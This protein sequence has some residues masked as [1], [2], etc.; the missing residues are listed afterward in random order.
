LN[1]EPY[2]N[3]TPNDP[4]SMAWGVE[5]LKKYISELRYLSHGEIDGNFDPMVYNGNGL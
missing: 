4:V 1:I 3:V 5:E 2:N